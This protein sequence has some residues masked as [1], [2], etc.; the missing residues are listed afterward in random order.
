MMDAKILTILA[1]LLVAVII[2][3]LA[4][5]GNLAFLGAKFDFSKKQSKA[6]VEKSKQVEVDQAGD[7]KA[8]VSDS[9]NVKIK[10]QN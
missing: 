8:K 3:L 4:R 9:E 2:V 6:D 10:Q 5:S 7:A 1:V